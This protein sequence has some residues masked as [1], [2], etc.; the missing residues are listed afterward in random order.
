MSK[1]VSPLSIPAMP[2][3][4]PQDDEASAPAQGIHAIEQI[5]GDPS[6]PGRENGSLV[7]GAFI[8]AFGCGKALAAGRPRASDSLARDPKGTSM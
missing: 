5:Y 4:I 7:S 3:L 8:M 6:R 1:A 2:R